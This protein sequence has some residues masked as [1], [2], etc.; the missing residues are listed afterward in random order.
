MSA[1][2]LGALIVSSKKGWE[3]V[4]FPQEG[5]IWRREGVIVYEHR[6]SSIQHKNSTL[7]RVCCRFISN[8][9]EYFN[10]RSLNLIPV[11]NQLRKSDLWA[12]YYLRAFYVGWISGMLIY[13]NFFSPPHVSLY[14]KLSLVRAK[15]MVNKKLQEL[16]TWSMS[17]I[18]FWT[19]IPH[20]RWTYLELCPT[21][22][23]WYTSTTSTNNFVVL[24]FCKRCEQIFSKH[25]QEAKRFEEKMCYE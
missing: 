11:S 22:E 12:A 15:N 2:S 21:R 18:I 7:Y 5:S 3:Q 17:F 8:N 4:V 24:R 10:L 23:S 1:W 14:S 16:R 13:N 9:V 20:R 19:Q 6:L 25:F